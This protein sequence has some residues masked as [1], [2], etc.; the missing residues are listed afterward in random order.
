MICTI[1]LR[2]RCRPITHLLLAVVICA[3][4]AWVWQHVAAL[5]PSLGA[6]GLDGLTTVGQ[7]GGGESVGNAAG[8]PRIEGIWMRGTPTRGAFSAF[9]VVFADTGSGQAAWRSGSSSRPE[10]GQLLATTAPV[11]HLCDAVGDTHQ[12]VGWVL[13]CYSAEVRLPATRPASIRIDVPQHVETPA[14]AVPDTPSTAVSPDASPAHHADVPSQHSDEICPTVPAIVGH[15]GVNY[16][17][18]NSF[19]SLRCC[20]IYRFLC[21]N[22]NSNIREIGARVR[23]HP[24]VLFRL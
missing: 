8:I 1:T 18:I 7:R 21:S 6:A 17:Q 5:G 19:G 15:S 14:P 24:P 16:V 4:R 12:T 23:E 11:T 10:V 2:R 13:E 22:C 20:C 9:G 3:H